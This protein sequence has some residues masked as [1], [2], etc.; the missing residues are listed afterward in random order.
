[1]IPTL[2]IPLVLGRRVGLGVGSGFDFR[3]K[4]RYFR[5]MMYYT[6]V[7]KRA[8]CEL[9]FGGFGVVTFYARS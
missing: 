5:Q 9:W 7:E 2:E 3:G 6:R 8:V 1:M 4:I